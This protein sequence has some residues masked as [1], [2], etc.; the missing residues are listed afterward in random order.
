M[1][2]QNLK[3]MTKVDGTFGGFDK[4]I[5]TLDFLLKHQLWKK[6]CKMLMVMM[7]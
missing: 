7:V 6:T 5:L 2:K 3:D 1:M 4:D